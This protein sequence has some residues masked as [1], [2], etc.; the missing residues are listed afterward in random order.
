M[1]EFIGTPQEYA[2]FIDELSYRNY[3]H[4]RQRRPEIPADR[5]GRL[6]LRWEAFEA[7]YQR[8]TLKAIE[9]V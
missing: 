7:R 6:F 4:N 5:W 3:A 8:E 9:V 2:T 1:A